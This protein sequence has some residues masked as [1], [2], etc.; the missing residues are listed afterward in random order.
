ML[1]FS[2][3]GSAKHDNVDKVQRSH[4]EWCTELAPEPERG[5]RAA[6]GCGACSRPSAQL[7][8]PGSHVAGHANVLVFPDLQAGNIGYKLVQRLGGR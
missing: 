1:S 4:R 5:R 2:T 6:G 7:K 8:A 3:K